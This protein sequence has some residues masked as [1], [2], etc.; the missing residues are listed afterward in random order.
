M[1]WSG[2]RPW[3][4]TTPRD[5]I[6]PTYPSRRKAAMHNPHTGWKLKETPEYRARRAKASEEW[7]KIPMRD[8]QEI[9]RLVERAK[10][11]ARLKLNN[12]SNKKIFNTQDHT[13]AK[14]GK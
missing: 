5:R 3:R 11:F 1:I 12:T 7:E 2:N 10:A 8:R 6:I 9:Y 4:I 14:H 13:E